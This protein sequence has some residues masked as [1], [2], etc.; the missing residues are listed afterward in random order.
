MAILWAGGEDIDFPNGT[1]ATVSTTASNFRS[2]YARC[3][4]AASQ[5]TPARSL[6]FIGGAITSEWLSFRGYANSP[7]ISS[8]LVGFGLSG[9]NK[10]LFVGTAAAAA[11]KCSLI[12][13]DGTTATELATES[14]TS[15][16]NSTLHRFDI[17]LVNYGSSATVSVWVDGT[18]VISGTFNVA[19]TG[20][21]NTDCVEVWGS[22]GFFFSEIIVAD[23]DTR[24]LSLVTMAPN[25]TGTTDSWTGTVPTNINPT[26]INDANSV[27]TNTAA[28]DEQANLIDFPSGTFTVRC[29]K[30]AARAM[31][32]AGAT[33]TKVALGINQGGTINAGTAQTTTTAFTTYERLMD[34]TNPVTGNPWLQS[35]MNG[36]QLN[37]RSS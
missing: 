4:I 31:S 11:T 27:F 6:A 23:E 25:A 30:I 26:T 24:S 32:T 12:K 7:S 10:G 17:Q 28:Q 18:Q 15:L 29:I 22:A 21:T 35:E 36:L 16:S 37:M 13:Y 1:I 9:G 2:G 3:A 19:V 8:R 34:A 5:T 20:M 33:A 14:G